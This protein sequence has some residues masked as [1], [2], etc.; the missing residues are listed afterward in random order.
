MDN[1]HITIVDKSDTGWATWR[2]EGIRW[3]L[4]NGDR[5][6]RPLWWCAV[7][8]HQKLCRVVVT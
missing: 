6:S 7:S 2:N 3:E 5:V 1:V 8:R 4:A